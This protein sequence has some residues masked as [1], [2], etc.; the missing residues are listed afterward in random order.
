MGLCLSANC[1][2]E[3]PVFWASGRL[4]KALGVERALNIAM[5]AYCLRLLCYL[6]SRT[7]P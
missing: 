3:V 2:A 4:L 6:V 5:A 7:H 1:A